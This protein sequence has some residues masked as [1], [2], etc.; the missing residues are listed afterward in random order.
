ML[1]RK[2]NHLKRP[3][4]PFCQ[5]YFRKLKFKF[6]EQDAKLEFLAAI[7]GDEPKVLQMG[8]NEEKGERANVVVPTHPSC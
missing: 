1:E 6:L 3:S 5:D 7:S 2:C 8:E 4:A